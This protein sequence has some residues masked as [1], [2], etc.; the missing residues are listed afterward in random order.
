MKSK[1]D[2]ST[3]FVP[4][5]SVVHVVTVRYQQNRGWQNSIQ[6]CAPRT[7]GN[8]QVWNVSEQFP[9]LGGL[10]VDEDIILYKSNGGCNSF[11]KAMEWAKSQGLR[12]TC[13][14]SVFALAEQHKFFHRRVAGS[15]VA[16]VASTVCVTIGHVDYVCAIMWTDELMEAKLLKCHI[17]VDIYDWFAF[18]PPAV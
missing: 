7:P 18:L 3:I 8:F 17:L 9:P 11:A 14:R 2:T 5:S 15:T 6:S 1:F 10:T 13:P 12:L 16:C 4:E